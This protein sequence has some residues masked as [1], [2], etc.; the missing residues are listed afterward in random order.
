[1]NSETGFD[2]KLYERFPTREDRPEGELAELERVWKAPI[3][4]ARLTAVNNNYVGIWYVATAFLFFLLAGVLALVMRVQL[5]LELPESDNAPV[6][7]AELGACIFDQLIEPAAN[8][9][10]SGRWRRGER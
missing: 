6:R 8:V 9:R 4:W 7:D 3:G 2:P 5:A 10:G 1:M